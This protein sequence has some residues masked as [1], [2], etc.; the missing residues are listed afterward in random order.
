IQPLQ[1]YINLGN[2][3]FKQDF[4]TAIVNEPGVAY[5]SGWAD[6]DNDGDLDLFV[7]RPASGSFMQQHLL[8]LNSGSFNFSKLT[9]PIVN[10]AAA[11]RGVVWTDYDND[12][13][14]DLYISND[15]LQNNF[16]YRNTGNQNS[17]VKFRLI[18][19]RSNPSAIGAKVRV[20]TSKGWQMREVAAQTGYCSQSDLTVHFGLASAN[21]IDS[22]VILWPSGEIC[23][24]TQLPANRLYFVD[25]DCNQLHQNYEKLIPVKDT[26]LCPGATWEIE[27][28][29]S[30]AVWNN[31]YIG[32]KYS[33]DSQGVYWVTIEDACIGKVSDT[34]RVNYSELKFEN[35]ADTFF[36]KNQPLILDFS[37][38]PYRFEWSNG[39]QQ[40]VVSISKPGMYA[41]TIAD[42]HGCISKDTFIVEEKYLPLNP[43]DFSD[44]V[45]CK[46]NSIKVALSGYNSV[47]WSD[48]AADSVRNF[49]KDGEYRVRVQ[50]VCGYAEDTIR[51]LQGSC[52]CI[53][54]MPDAFTPNGDNINDLFGPMYDCEPDEYEIKIF[55]RWG[56]CIFQTTQLSE[57]WDGT[58]KSRDVPT[59]VY[60][61]FVRYRNGAKKPNI[62]EGRVLL[63]R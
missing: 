14:L 63:L 57:N 49:D 32:P 51:I 59:G 61:Y 35:V 10:N 34:V 33:I 43:I 28:S 60:T 6:L 38:L 40:P 36:C 19:I 42:Q 44:T 26:T 53:L 54:S 1:I 15:S 39:E 18:G 48:G 5:G 13:F 58:Y 25:E 17:W 22:V 27:V 37:H 8:F 45:L 30:L 55:N 2:G 62:I 56:E 20:K 21:C 4:T 46:G 12:G 9:E 11:S 3:S 41:L 52:D 24:Y 31:T 50:N 23:S 29:D 47:L 7:A 16:L